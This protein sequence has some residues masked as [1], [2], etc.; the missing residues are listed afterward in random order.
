MGRPQNQGQ[1]NKMFN[2]SSANNAL[3]STFPERSSNLDDQ[4]VL[5]NYTSRSKQVDILADFQGSNT[6]TRLQ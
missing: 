5:L 3:K 4:K 1:D 2:L 6:R